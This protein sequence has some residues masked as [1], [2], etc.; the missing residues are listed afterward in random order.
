MEALHVLQGEFAS[1]DV[2]AYLLDHAMMIDQR[3]RYPAINRWFRQIAQTDFSGT[4]IPAGVAQGAVQ[5][6]CEIW[7]RF[8]SHFLAS[9]RFA[10]RCRPRSFDD[11]SNSTGRPGCLISQRK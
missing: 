10:V 3:F 5:F 7:F 11:A 2:G 8:F 4:P 1:R 9:T 6:G